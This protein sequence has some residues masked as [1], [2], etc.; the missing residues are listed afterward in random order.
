MFDFV[1]RIPGRAQNNIFY[2]HSHVQEF[3]HHIGHV[4]HSGIHAPDMQVG[5][6][7]IWQEPLMNGGVRLAER[8]AGATM[9]Y[10]KNYAALLRVE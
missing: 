2:R 9:A 6:N 3:R 8:K 5:R 4:F 10:I 7:R 1:G